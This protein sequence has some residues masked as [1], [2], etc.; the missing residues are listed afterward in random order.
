MVF[1]L[2]KILITFLILIVLFVTSGGEESNVII[3]KDAIRFRVIA[4][5]NS[6]ID[7]KEKKK[8]ANKLG[9]DITTI[10]KDSNSLEESRSILKS[11]VGYF[12]NVVESTMQED[13]Y[14][15]SVDVDYGYHVFPQ[16]EYKGVIYEE[17]EYES[18]VVTLG[19]GS[20]KNFWCVL[21]PPLC[22]LEAEEEEE[23]NKV[24]Y[25]SLIKEVLDKY[26]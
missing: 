24:E 25:K 4:N 26:F 22:L 23:T 19:E 14:D 18:L 16:K 9:T 12:Q 8:I 15:S 2:K 10:L 1:L 6:E 3:P 20:G 17:G 13:Q 5:S 7:Q 21:F 11:K